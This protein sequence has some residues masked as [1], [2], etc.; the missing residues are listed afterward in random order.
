ML[1]SSDSSDVDSSDE[2]SDPPGCGTV[3]SSGKYFQPSKK[4]GGKSLNMFK[5]SSNLEP[6]KPSSFSNNS[7]KNILKSKTI[8]HSNVDNSSA[9]SSFLFNPISVGSSSSSGS[10]NSSNKRKLSEEDISNLINSTPSIHTSNTTT[11]ST[12]SS[13]TS[14]NKPPAKKQRSSSSGQRTCKV[15]KKQHLDS[16]FARHVTTHLYQLWPEVDR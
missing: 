9:G 2:F 5:N 7:N 4:P 8:V 6:V 13:T 1:S 12:I 15:C 14:S 10:S 3:G 16:Q 11:T